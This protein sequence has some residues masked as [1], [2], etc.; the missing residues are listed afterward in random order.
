MSRSYKKSPVEKLKNDKKM[1]KLLSKKVRKAENLV[2]GSHYKKCMNMYDI[3][4]FR[5]FITK[6]DIEKNEFL[7]KHIQEELYK[8]FMK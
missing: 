5:S 2:D 8:V 1:K 6:D 4:D 3:C 7:K